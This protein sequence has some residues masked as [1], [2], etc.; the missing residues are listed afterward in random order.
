MQDKPERILSAKETF[1]PRGRTGISNSTG[2][3]LVRRGDFPQPVQL[4]AGRV[5][6]RESDVDAW[7][8][9]RPTVDF[10]KPSKPQA[11]NKRGIAA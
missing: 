1:G 3:E 6:W 2:Y 5:G 10:R 7:I 9:S 8:K 4:T 11:D